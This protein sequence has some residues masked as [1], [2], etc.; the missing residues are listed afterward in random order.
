LRIGIRV[1]RID[2]RPGQGRGADGAGGDGKDFQ[3]VTPDDI[4]DFVT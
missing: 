2:E 4:L 3:K 1:Q